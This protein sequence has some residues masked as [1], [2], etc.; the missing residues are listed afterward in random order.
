VPSTI[1]EETNMKI[2]Q[3]LTALLFSTVA[4]VA[5]AQTPGYGANIT[6][7]QAKVVLAAAEAEAVKQ[8]F[9]VAVAVVDTAGNLVAFSKGDNTQIA[10]VNISQGKAY[11]AV[12]FKRPTKA[13]QDTI[14]AGG[15]GLRTLTLEGVVAAEGGVPLVLN[16]QIVGA[17]G[18]SGMTS[19]QDGVIAAA[20]VAALK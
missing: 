7:A 13:L 8:N 10:S 19:E 16:G 4:V 1:P 11:T 9:T 2:F 17:I 20:G 15:V 14:A 3:I 12:G 5:Q 18:V 6:L